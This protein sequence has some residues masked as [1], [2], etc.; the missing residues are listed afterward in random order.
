MKINSIQN[1]NFKGYDAAP[2]SAI[3]MQN[4]IADAFFWELEEIA[5]KEGFEVKYDRDLV[6]WSQDH[7]TIIEK[8]KR[9][10]LLTSRLFGETNLEAIK[11]SYKISGTIPPCYIEGGNCFIGKYPNGEKWMM[12][13]QDD[14]IFD[15]KSIAKDYNIKAKNIIQIPQQDFHLDM[16]MRPIGYPYVLVNNPELVREKIKELNTDGKFDEL[17]KTFLKNEQERQNLYANHKKVIKALKKIGFIP[18]EVA[19]VFG[20]G[21]NFMNAIVNQHSNGKMTYITN[22]TM[23]INGK[24]NVFQEIFEQ[25]L[26]QKAPDIEKVYFINGVLDPETN[27]LMSELERFDGGLH[28]MVAEEPNFRMWV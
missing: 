9:P 27:F 7:K 25:E 3:H 4:K 16:F 10:F 2:L 14:C 22:G 18:I 17:E 28:C 15:K 12:V 20:S 11:K 13:G 19:G 21:V 8:R 6:K 5:K 26:R 1:Y 23:S 24:K